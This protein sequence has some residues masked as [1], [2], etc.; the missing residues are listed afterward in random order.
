MTAKALELSDADLGRALAL[1]DGG[2]SVRTLA[3]Q[4]GVSKHVAHELARAARES[5]TLPAPAVVATAPNADPDGSAIPGA[6]TDWKP[7]RLDKPANPGP[8]HP[9]SWPTPP[10]AVG[11][12]EPGAAPPLPAETSIESRAADMGDDEFHA[13]IRSLAKDAAARRDSK[14]LNALELALFR[15]QRN[16]GKARR[17]AEDAAG[18]LDLTRLTDVELAVYEA[19]IAKMGAPPDAT[20]DPSPWLLWINSAA[21]PPS[22]A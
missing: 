5:L 18:E 14:T 15:A 6:P 1:L 22:A 8:L 12:P 17:A 3:R 2:A 7:P 4:L 11:A 16:D 13:L 10:R 21:S 20:L 9:E 19:L